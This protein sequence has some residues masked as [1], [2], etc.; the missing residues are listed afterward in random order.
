M[1]T[2]Q[3]TCAERI[4]EHWKGRAEDLR[5]LLPVAQGNIPAPDAEDDRQALVNLGIDADDLDNED[6]ALESAQERLWEM[7]LSIEMVRVVRVL[8]STGGPEDAIEYTLDSDGDVIRAEYVFKDWF[9][10]ARKP[11]DGDDFS[12]A[13]GFF[14]A[15]V[16]DVDSLH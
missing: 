7:P 16:P 12:T 3:R 14:E 2:R 10:G 4:G 11:L 5:A 15:L 6:A 13:L 1:A 9:D 8:L